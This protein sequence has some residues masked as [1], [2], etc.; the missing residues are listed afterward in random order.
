VIVLEPQEARTGAVVRVKEGY[1]KRDLVGLRGTV[2]KCW[3]HPDYAA[4][5]IM[6]EDGRMELLWV[7][8]LDV[9]RG[10]EAPSGAKRFL[11]RRYRVA[12]R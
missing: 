8:E 3:G 12:P 5:D 2:R 4:V 6:L 9:V 10:S 11:P 1:R 7:H